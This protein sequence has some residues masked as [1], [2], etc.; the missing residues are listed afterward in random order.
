MRFIYGRTNNHLRS[1]SGRAWNILK[2]VAL[3]R[4]A[5]YKICETTIS[6]K[7]NI[8]EVHVAPAVENLGLAGSSLQNL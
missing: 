2:I 8:C 3:I 5:F 6:A 1:H 4:W 7:H